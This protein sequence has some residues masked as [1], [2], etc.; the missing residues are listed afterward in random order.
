MHE[1]EWKRARRTHDSSLY[2]DISN[3]CTQKTAQGDSAEQ[4]KPPVPVKTKRKMKCV[5]WDDIK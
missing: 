1:P 3:K 5:N 2:S 4:M